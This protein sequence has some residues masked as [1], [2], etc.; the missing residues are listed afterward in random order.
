MTDEYDPDWEQDGMNVNPFYQ[1]HRFKWQSATEKPGKKV[2]RNPIAH[3]ATCFKTKREKA[4]QVYD[5]ANNKFFC[6]DACETA[7]KDNHEDEEN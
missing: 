7:R 4:F 6:D 5:V 1:K 3:C 2:D